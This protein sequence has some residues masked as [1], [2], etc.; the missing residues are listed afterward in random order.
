MVLHPVNTY[1]LPGNDFGIFT[2]IAFSMKKTTHNNH[3]SSTPFKI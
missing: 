2:S 3:Q 1:D